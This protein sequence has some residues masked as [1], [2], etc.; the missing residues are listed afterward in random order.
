MVE[1][2]KGLSETQKIKL[3]HYEFRDGLGNVAW[4]SVERNVRVLTLLL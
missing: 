1:G 2:V 3:P 4:K